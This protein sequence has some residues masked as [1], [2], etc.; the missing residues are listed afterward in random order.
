MMEKGEE[1][2]PRKTEEGPRNLSRNLQLV[3]GEGQKV[4]QKKTAANSEG[5]GKKKESPR[6]EGTSRKK[7]SGGGNFSRKK[8][9]IIITRARGGISR[10]GG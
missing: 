4:G 10:L 3:K 6:R 9:Q 7:P 5:T 2:W 8:V 1:S